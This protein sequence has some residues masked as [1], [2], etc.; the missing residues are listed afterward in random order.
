MS[1]ES[2]SQTVTR[3][4]G[5]FL[6]HWGVD[7]AQYH[8]L[9][10]ASLK[11]DFRSTS[12]LATGG[13]SSPTQ[14]ALLVNGALNSLFSL[15][16]SVSLVAGGASEFFFS[17]VAIGYAMVMVGM[18][19]LIEFGLVVIS[20]DDFLIL[21]HRPVSSR[22]FFAVKFSN[23]CF[24]ILILGASLNV[25]PAFVGLGCHG[26][27]WYFPLI[28]LAVSTFASLFVAGS[29]VAL[30]G[31]VLRRVNYE[32]FKDLLV[33]VQIAFSFF[34]FFGYQVAPRVAGNVEGMDISVLTHSW[35][36]IFPSVWFA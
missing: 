36:V 2:S 7:A 14:S 8:W 34:F 15:I 31:L 1:A 11:M 25:I 10:Q 6:S 22:T 26:S 35:A 17:V 18:S 9:L 21:A 23:L 32:K 5:S 27:R 33:Y 4:L 16:I 19:I 24:Y 28:Y 20:P 30:Y 29:I 3:R 12:T 13:G